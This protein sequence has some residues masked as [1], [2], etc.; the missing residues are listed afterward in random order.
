MS[1]KLKHIVLVT[2]FWIV[3]SHAQN[4]EVQF[5]LN[6][7]KNKVEVGEPVNAKL[8]LTFSETTL[9]GFSK[10]DIEYP[11]VTDS[12]KLPNLEIW[13]TNKPIDTI[14]V[15][16][17]DET[18]FIYEQNFTV[19]AFDTGRIE[20]PPFLSVFNGDSIY[21]NAATLLV[22][23]VPFD[24]NADF[25][26]IKP[27]EEDP[28]SFWEKFKI[29]LKNN[30]TW[31]TIFV[32][33]VFGIIYFIYLKKNKKEEGP[34]KPK[35]PTPDRLLYR[36]NEIDQAKLWQKDQVKQYYSEITDVIDEYLNY[37][38]D[39]PTFEKTS[40]EIISGLK[41]KSIDSENLEQLEKL[42]FLSDMVKFAKSLPTEE[43]HKEALII[44]RELIKKYKSKTITKE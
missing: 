13:K 5:N 11:F 1:I 35:I 23:F 20:I 38:F 39:I 6:V 8:K 7:D 26:D 30:W 24:K 33:V 14:E 29:W 25:K 15:N 27:L 2:I 12:L 22:S 21:S 31:I 36:L 42:F 9:N 4:N 17:N 43:E 41:L 28:L 37:R 34:K 16:S 3:N 44:A 19:A 40:H 32:I 10:S 18:T